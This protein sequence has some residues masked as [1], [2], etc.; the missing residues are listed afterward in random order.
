MVEMVVVVA[1]VGI[2]ASAVVPFMKLGEQRVKERELRRALRDIRGGIDAYRQAASEG[3][4]TLNVDASGYPP[5]LDAL[6]EGVP[7]AKSV[8][9]KKIYFLRR[10]P[11]DPFAEPG[12][13]LDEVWG[14]RSY[15]SPPDD[16]KPGEDVFDVYSLSPGI[17]SNGVPYRDW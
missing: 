17:G 14:L 5:H 2:L 13:P 7:D 8:D 15:A 10:I 1:I 16:P 4:L 11:R 12:T 6:T 9:S 3:R